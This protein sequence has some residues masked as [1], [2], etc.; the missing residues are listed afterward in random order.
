MGRVADKQR[1]CSTAASILQGKIA[2]GDFDVF[3]CHK[4]KQEVKKVGEELKEQGILPWLD[5]WELQPGLPWQAVLEKQM[6]KIKASAVFVGKDGVGPW[7]DMELQAFLRQFMT[8]EQKCPIIPVI[9]PDCKDVPQ[10]PIFLEGMTWVDFREQV[11]DP[12]K[13]L[14][15]RIT[16][17]RSEH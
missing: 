13:Q 7:R 6:K 10:L 9:L 11:P 4:N 5:E 15:W 3:L 17:E 12:M 8:R 1:D 14:I 2:I 16:G